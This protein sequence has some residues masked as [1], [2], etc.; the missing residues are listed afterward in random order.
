MQQQA[1]VVWKG[2][3]KNGGGEISTASGAVKNIP[4]S[5]GTRFEQVRGTNP[6]ELIGAAHASCFTMALSGAL[7]KKGF[8]INKIITQAQIFTELDGDVLTLTAS[9][10]RVEA[11]VPDLSESQLKSFA[12]EVKVSCPISRA[13]NLQISVETK[14]LNSKQDIFIEHMI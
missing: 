12:E 6:E 4:Y 14:L 11:D 13:L 5:Y 10:L 2:S 3:I 9:H 7:T 8:E 1:S